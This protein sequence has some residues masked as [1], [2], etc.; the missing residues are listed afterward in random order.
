MCFAKMDDSGLTYKFWVHLISVSDGLL[1]VSELDTVV[2]K[3]LVNS[4]LSF[5]A[6]FSFALHS[7]S[8]HLHLKFLLT[9]VRQVILCQARLVKAILFT[10]EDLALR[11]PALSP[12]SPLNSCH[13]Q[14]RE[15][16][17][18]SGHHNPLPRH[19][20]YLISTTSECKADR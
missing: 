12:I 3:S 20:Q 15:S 7:P 18:Q 8:S 17:N 16:L 4:A 13:C 19:C 9:G 14:A 2:C 5:K 6:L 11:L 10:K 1:V